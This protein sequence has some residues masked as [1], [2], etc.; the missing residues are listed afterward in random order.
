MCVGGELR[1]EEP[2]QTHAGPLLPLV[3]CGSYS[4]I[5]GRGAKG[6]EWAQCQCVGSY[7]TVSAA[8]ETGPYI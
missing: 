4:G 1:R 6:T 2:N 7:I 8:Q 3:E 5:Y